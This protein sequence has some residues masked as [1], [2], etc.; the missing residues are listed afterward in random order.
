MQEIIIRQFDDL[1]F[2]VDTQHDGLTVEAMVVPYNREIEAV[3]IRAD[4][5]V[6]Y[7]E[8]FRNGSN[9]RAVKAP[10]R[11]G[12]TFLHDETFGALLGYG[13]QFREDDDGLFGHFRLYDSTAAKARDVL[14]STHRSLSVG[15]V[16]ITPRAGTE[17]AGSLVERMSVALRHAAA[18]PQGQYAEAR[19]LALRAAQEASET[20][21]VWEGWT[22]DGERLRVLDPEPGPDGEPPMPPEPPD[23][24][25]DAALFADIDALISSQRALDERFGAA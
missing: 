3:D 14:E 25:R 6:S 9:V 15:F 2:R 23:T 18:V 16:S 1:R 19:V 7:R 21:A 17:A 5:L 11:V 8:V 20:P 24:K 22:P 10:N 12:L 4:G 13:K